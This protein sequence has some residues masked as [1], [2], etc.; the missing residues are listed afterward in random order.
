MMRW[1]KNLKATPRLMLSFG[2]LIAFIAGIGYLGIDSLRRSNERTRVLYQEDMQG[3][4][5]ANNIV[6]ARFAVGK[7][8]RDALIHIDEDVGDQPRDAVDQLGAIGDFFQ[9][10]VDEDLDLRGGHATAEQSASRTASLAVRVP[11]SADRNGARPA[12]Y[13]ALVEKPVGV[14]EDASV[15]E[16]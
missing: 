15:E 4:V 14:V 3:A 16:Y 12:R 1:F 13:E 7:F 6:K 2:V 5:Q 9:D 10:L 8:G 11:S